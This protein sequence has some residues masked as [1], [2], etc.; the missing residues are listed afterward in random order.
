MKTF[1]M[2]LALGFGISLLLLPKSG[3][4]HEELMREKTREL[5]RSLPQTGEREL[6]SASLQQ[7]ERFTR[8][9]TPQYRSRTG[10]VRTGIHPIVVL[11][12]ATEEELLSAGV[13]PE[14]ASKIAAG[15]P[16]TSLQDAMDR[17]LLSPGT[18]A[19]IQQ[20]AQARKPLPLQPMA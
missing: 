9:G 13:E 4:E 6:Q 16:Y 7:R 1:V 10:A 8:P 12:T 18:L 3:N 14:L 17:G 2:G 20:A 11:N 19:I 15:R 5:Q